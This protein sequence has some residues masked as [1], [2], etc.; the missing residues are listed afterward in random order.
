VKGRAEPIDLET[1]EIG[2]H[3]TPIVAKDSVIIGSS[4][5]EGA[6]VPT[7]NNTKGLVRAFEVVDANVQTFTTQV[8]RARSQFALAL[9]FLNLRA[10]L[11]L[12]PLGEVPAP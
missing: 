8:E 12:D 4:M 3:S 6:T 9:T 1:G 11:G 10:A 5:R 2:I 7:H